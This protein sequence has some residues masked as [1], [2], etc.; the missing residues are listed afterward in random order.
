MNIVETKKFS[1]GKETFSRWSQERVMNMC[2]KIF[3]AANELVSITGRPGNTLKVGHDLASVLFCAGSDQIFV[4]SGTVFGCIGIL[5]G[6][7]NVWID[8]D[9]KPNEAEISYENTGIKLIFD[10]LELTTEGITFEKE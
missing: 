6:H 1:P 2:R 3:E 8:E 4:P 5:N 9:L 7:V 10:G